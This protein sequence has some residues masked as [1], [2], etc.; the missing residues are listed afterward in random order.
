MKKILLTFL[1][2][3][4]IMT[5]QAQYLL[6]QIGT[7]PSVAF[8]LRL[9]KSTY[10]GPLVRIYVG[11]SFY[12]VYPDASTKNFSLS[13]KISAAIG[14][15]NAAVSAPSANALSSIITA[16]TTNA[17]VAIWYDQS[18]NS[19]HVLTNNPN[20]KI[21]TSGSIN[22]VNSQPTINFT[23]TNSFL[24]SSASVNYS[25]QTLATINAV[26]Q[27]VASTNYIS[28]IISVGDNGGWGLCYDPTT[29]IKG[30]WVDASGGNGALSN[31]LTTD[32]KVV[33]GFIG[34]ATNSSIY[35]N[36]I[37]KG[38]K[39]AQAISNGTND[40]IY[41]GT[42]G[43]FSGRQF[44]G[45]ISEV[46]LFP[47]NLSST[48]QSTLESSQSIF[49]PPVVTITSSAAGAVCAGTS[50]TFTATTSGITSPSFQWYK[51]S[52]A[53]SGATSAT[54]TTT[55]LSN[56]DQIYAM[57]TPGYTSGSISTSN[58]IANFDAA[59]Y[60]T[61][62]TRW[63]DLSASANHMDFYTSN[64]Y[65]TLKTATYLAD[66]GGSLNVNNNSIYG[67]TINTTGIS[68]N[69][70]KTMS[71]WVK[72]D[73]ADRDWTSI[74]SIGAYDNYAVLFEI[75][76][77]RN[78]AGHQIML[79]F[80]GG[81]VPGIT[82]IPL[83]TW[84]NVTIKADGSSLKVFVNG[85]LD[86]TGNQTLST[87]NSPL[88]LGAP[89]SYSNGGWDNNLRGRISTLSLY[90]AALSDQT[91][92]DNYNATKGRYTVSS[93]SS[94]TLTASI[95]A[96]PSAVVSV[97]GDGC[98]N[99][100]TLS[101]P[102]G[103]T[104]YAWYKDNVAISSTN[105]NTYLPSTSGDYKVLVTS[106]S[107][108]TLS[109]ATN[110]TVCGV[111]ADGKMGPLTS[112]ALVSRDGATN[113]GN[114]I[115]ERGLLLA[116]PWTFGTVTSPYTSKVWMDRNLGATRVATS[117]N[118]IA[119][120]GDLYQWGRATDGGQLRTAPTTA[121]KLPTYTTQSIN[122]I[123]TQPWTSDAN[124]N[125]K[126]GNSWDQQPWNNTDGGVN[127]PC[128]SGYRVPT[129]SEW[130]AE[131]SGMISAGLVTNSGAATNIASGSFSSFLKIPQAGVYENGSTTLVTTKTVFWTTDRLDTYS[132]NEIRFWPGQGAYQNA[133][134]YS[135]RYSVRCI[136]K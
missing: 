118:D 130:T 72:F 84:A 68:G 15:Y 88:Y 93:V 123:T 125:T 28:G 40:K 27:N 19:I 131:L 65:S 79:V 107:C 128:P 124:W 99:K 87:T 47:T 76:G 136:A 90:N 98:I 2:S 92:L 115:D 14:S 35:I 105:T 82:T 29:T 34:T 45:N 59:N 10:S 95:T 71:A 8:S 96:G 70:G 94:T 86:A 38:T 132:A 31:E 73:A 101:T 80:A 121:T 13:S 77:S 67:K 17:T 41:I 111:T 32:V 24:T 109:A 25:A 85:V 42:R 60:T 30:Y 53:I 55:S 119:S 37:Q 91:I 18:G 112:S 108:S 57:A 133:N 106:G 3:L 16:G 81:L 6:D 23:G 129:T 49:I 56:S 117:V 135:F 46:F 66:G 104:S 114:G 69:G 83:N 78:G 62:S 4:G 120:Y 5:T 33:T 63:N 39:S 58:L 54:Y 113:N 116:V 134:W 11:T 97:S 26:A 20:A 103:Q 61:S 75:F 51:N 100:T 110:I 44:I 50:V 36:S 127:N 64:S 74:A 52:V 48:D 22:T 122:Y 89:V 9:L 1:F 43:N 7:F 102:A 21:I 126:T 12:D